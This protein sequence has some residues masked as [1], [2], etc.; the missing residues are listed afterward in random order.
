MKLKERE[1]IVLR[2]LNKLLMFFFTFKNIFFQ[3]EFYVDSN[4]TKSQEGKQNERNIYAASDLS[5]IHI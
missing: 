1:I 5:L 2:R 4:H 3:A